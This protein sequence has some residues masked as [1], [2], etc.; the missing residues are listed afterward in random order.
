MRRG[1][2]GAAP[3]LSPSVK[4]NAARS[5][6][7]STATGRGE[8]AT[9]ERPNLPRLSLSENA[10]LK[11]L[12]ARKVRD[13]RA[14]T[15]SPRSRAPLRRAS[16]GRGGGCSGCSHDEMRE[17]RQHARLMV[18]GARGIGLMRAGGLSVSGREAHD[19]LKAAPEHALA[20]ERHLARVHLRL[21]LGILPDRSRDAIAVLSALVDNPRHCDHLVVL[22]LHRLRERRELARL[23]VVTG[24]IGE[25]HCAVAQ[26]RLAGQLVEL[27]L[28][29][30]TRLR[31]RCR[32]IGDRRSVPAL[33]PDEK[34]NRNAKTDEACRE[35]RRD[36]Y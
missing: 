29:R 2:G 13:R 4:T 31:S 35:D 23:D 19:G 5:R 26:M 12:G 1:R 8:P 28:E 22:E 30:V 21:E 36:R 18:A 7:R 33:T 25:V 34:P 16:W 20:V 14:K 27:L 6:A 17:L 15:P 3:Y 24:G 32:L 11:S 10:P 9:G